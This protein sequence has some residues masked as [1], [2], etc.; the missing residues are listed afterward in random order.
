M[1][2]KKNV[3]ELKCSSL[4]LNVRFSCFNLF[5]YAILPLFWYFHCQLGYAYFHQYNWYGFVYVLWQFFCVF[6]KP[7]FD[8]VD[9]H[10]P[11]LF[12]SHHLQ[13]NMLSLSKRILLSH[14]IFIYDHLDCMRVWVCDFCHSPSLASLCD[15]R[16]STTHC[17][18]EQ[19]LK[20]ETEKK[21]PPPSP[22]PAC[23][24]IAFSQMHINICS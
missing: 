21:D 22:S 15:I 10:I 23:K 24:V 11:T 18:I 2:I 19:L 4:Y 13:S 9:S 20:G 7:I 6:Y 14:A 12:A 3:F 1:L 16:R 5:F 17:F 8:S